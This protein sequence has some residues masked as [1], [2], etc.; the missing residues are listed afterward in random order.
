MTG[1][2]LVVFDSTKEYPQDL[3]ANEIH[4]DLE[5]QVVFVPINGAPTPFH[6]SNI[7]SVVQPDPDRAASYLRLDFYTPG[8]SLGKDVPLS[9]VAMIEAYGKQSVFVKEM[10]FRSREPRRLNAAFRMIQELRKR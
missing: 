9:T 7:K 6:V 8:V 10:L 4:V 5:N 3:P 2:E 1:E